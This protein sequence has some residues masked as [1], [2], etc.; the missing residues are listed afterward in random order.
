M[1][2]CLLLTLPSLPTLPHRYTVALRPYASGITL[3]LEII[4][5]CV[6]LVL[7]VFSLVNQMQL[8]APSDPPFVALV[9]CFVGVGLVILIEVWRTI[10][11]AVALS[12]RP[13]LDPSQDAETVTQSGTVYSSRGSDGYE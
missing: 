8:E 3:L 4:L 5:S 13:I 2:T 12:R 6:E 10:T 1:L 7:L 11:I 9:L